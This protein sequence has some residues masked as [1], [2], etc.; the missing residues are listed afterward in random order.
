MAVL[1]GGVQAWQGVGGEVIT[2]SSDKW[3]LERQVRFVA[4]TLVVLGILG[5]LIIPE[6]IWFAGA[7]GLGQ[8]LAAATN[9][10]A[11]GA[12]LARLPYNR[13]GV[14]QREIERSVAALSS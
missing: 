1:D 2:G 8:I 13:S 9:S 5:S 4:G 12:L 3:A 7:I 6:L 10:C 14:D 11:M